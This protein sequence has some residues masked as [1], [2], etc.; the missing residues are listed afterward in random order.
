M[1]MTENY[2]VITRMTSF[3]YPPVT[4]V[5]TQFISSLNNLCSDTHTHFKLIESMALM[6]LV[7][8]QITGLLLDECLV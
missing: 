6:Y 5:Q 1:Y 8:N 3:I 7:K 2:H 4:V